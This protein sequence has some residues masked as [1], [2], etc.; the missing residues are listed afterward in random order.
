MYD[1]SA[2]L[3]PADFE[4]LRGSVRK[5]M[6]QFGP[7]YWAA[8]DRDRGFPDAFFA[9]AGAAGL[10][11]TMIPPEFGGEGAGAEAASVI[12]E[13]VNRAG[14]DATTINAQMSIC[15][16]LIRA[17]DTTQRALLPAIARGEVRCLTVAATEPDSG[18]DMSAVQSS[19]VREGDGWRINAKKVLISL[20]EHT[21]L[22][23]VLMK[24]E[25][26]S[27]V[28]LLDRR[29]PEVDAA[30]EIRPI[31]MVTNRLTTVLFIDGLYVPD[32]A[33]VGVVGQGL[34]ALAQGF[35]HRRVFAAAECIGNARFMLDR[36]LEHARDRQTFNRPIG[37]N[38]GIQ[39]PLSSAYAKVEGADLMR[40][41]ALRASAAREPGAGGRSAMAKVLASEAAWETARAALTTYGGWGL[42]GEYHVERKLRDSMVYVFNNMLLSYISDNVLKLPKAF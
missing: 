38:Q 9:A 39:Y 3:G 20:A 13:E 18:A 25:E 29:D 41:D 5:L 10:Y 2:I 23:M 17:G 40:W 12:I 21:H 33:R 27:T 4:T 32:S 6:S 26:G 8:L 19:A 11:G 7:E 28:F 24:T 31:D 1:A 14:G 37:Q 34:S 22:M 36:A 15:G 30:I 35:V 42:S 16:T